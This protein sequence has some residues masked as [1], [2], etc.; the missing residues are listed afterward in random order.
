MLVQH[1]LRRQVRAIKSGSTRF[2]QVRLW[3]GGDGVLMYLDDILTH[4]Q[5]TMKK[6]AAEL[7]ET[8]KVKLMVD[9]FSVEKARR[10]PASSGVPTLSPSG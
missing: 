1:T 3:R 5:A 10:T 2:P 7:G 6:F 4:A 9:K 8:F